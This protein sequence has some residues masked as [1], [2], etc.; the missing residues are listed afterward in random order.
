MKWV[1]R[2]LLV[3]SA[4]MILVI[5]AAVFSSRQERPVSRM[6]A[7]DSEVLIFGKFESLANRPVEGGIEMTLNGHHRV[8]LA[9]RELLVNDILHGRDFSHA[10]IRLAPDGRL[11]TTV[12]RDLQ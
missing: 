2:F 11:K 8:V 4:L 10:E 3:T 7:G 12:H 5:V 9:N 1:K 6:T